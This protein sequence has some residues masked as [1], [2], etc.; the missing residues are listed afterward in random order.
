MTVVTLALWI[1]SALLPI[2]LGFN[3]ESDGTNADA[4]YSAREIRQ[5]SLMKARTGEAIGG[6]SASGMRIGLSDD[7]LEASQ[8]NDGRYHSQKQ[9]ERKTNAAPLCDGVFCAI[10]EET[11]E[12]IAL[13]GNGW[14]SQAQTTELRD[15]DKWGLVVRLNNAPS[16]TMQDFCDVLFL[17]WDGVCFHQQRTGCADGSIHLKGGKGRYM[18]IRENNAR[19][20]HGMP[21]AVVVLTPEE[22]KPPL[23]A[24]ESMISKDEFIILQERN[25]ARWAHNSTNLSDYGGLK[26]YAYGWSTGFLALGWLSQKYPS[27]QIHVFGMN[28][29]GGQDSEVDD[30]GTFKG[31]VRRALSVIGW[32]GAPQQ[33]GHAFHIEKE[34]ITKLIP[35][36]TLHATPTEAY[37]FDQCPHYDSLACMLQGVK[38]M[39]FC[40]EYSRTFIFICTSICITTLMIFARK[41]LS[42]FRGLFQ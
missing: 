16:M 21:P 2:T 31:V 10:D 42:F 36:V 22:V 33:Y 30:W 6:A 3:R 37:C 19:H 38:G 9:T 28:W 41:K 26:K 34:I 20:N 39:F 17:R 7:N 4:V 32:S 8:S 13:V 12:R 27:S 23:S 35:H 29:N 40:S 25:I 5:K 11:P 1:L 15:R 14:L 24:I 18:E